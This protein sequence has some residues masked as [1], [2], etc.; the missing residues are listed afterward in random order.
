MLNL[1]YKLYV[2]GDNEVRDHDRLTG[3]Y[4][5]SAHWSCEINLKLT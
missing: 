1:L 4:R 5:V 2:A 3:K